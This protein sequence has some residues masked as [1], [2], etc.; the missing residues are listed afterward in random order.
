[1]IID[2]HCHIQFRGYDND[3]AEVI[4]RCR[5]KNT[6]MNAVGTQFDTSRAAVE[7][8]EANPDIYATIGLHPIHLFSTHVDEEESSF[9]SREEK[10]DY[11]TYL[12]LGQSKKVIGVGE[13]GLE[14]FHI[15]PE[16]DRG[17]ILT[18][19]KET[20]LLQVKLAKELN[21][22]LVI[23]I[24]EAYDEMLELLNGLNKQIN[25]VVHCYSGNW[26]QA[27]GFLDLGLY[28]GFTGVVT[29]PAKKTNPQPTIDLLE[30]VKNFSGN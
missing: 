20:F 16:A 17:V 14:L 24:R 8:A 19:Q 13:C 1:M 10:F 22:P 27:Q 28:L 18:R 11:D 25:G 30:V 7:L 21:V 6:I 2:T 5:E 23:H 12:K 29:F 15:P 3:R 4:K 9:E 26:R